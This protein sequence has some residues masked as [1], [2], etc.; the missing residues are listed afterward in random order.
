MAQILKE[1]IRKKIYQAALED[2]F[3]KDFKRATIRNM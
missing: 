1:E 2:F 3:E